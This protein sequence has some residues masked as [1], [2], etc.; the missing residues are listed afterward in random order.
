MQDPELWKRISE[1]HPDD[2]EAD[3]P[4]SRRLARDNGWSHDFALSVITEYQR[5]AYLSRMKSGMVTPSDEVDQAWHLHLTYTRHYW[6]VFKD[7]LGGALHHMPTKGGAG[8]AALF[9]EAYQKTLDLYETEFGARPPEDTWPSPDVRFGR[10][11]HFQRINTKDVWVVP[12]PA[13]PKPLIR[14]WTSLKAVPAKVYGGLLGFTALLFGTGL[15]FAHGEPSG[16]TLVEKLR[17]M[18]WHWASEHT[19]WFVFGIVVA[20]LILKAMMQKAS[21]NASGCGSTCG[22]DGGGGGGSGCGGCGD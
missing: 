3:F 6:G 12:K 8:Q 22:S 13:W 14:A 20:V 4:F 17:N 9:R 21:G 15:A 1:C 16:D 18:V 19:L 5:F 2:V 11:P 10:A 7:A